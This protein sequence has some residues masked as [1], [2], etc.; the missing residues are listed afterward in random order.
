M[1]LTPTSNSW[2]EGACQEGRRT[3]REEQRWARQD[4]RLAQHQQV[5]QFGINAKFCF[6]IIAMFIDYHAVQ[7]W[8]RHNP[9]GL[10]QHERAEAELGGGEVFL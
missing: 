9:L 10:W 6:I 3:L 8:N 4:K 1:I 7:P 2:V 5:K